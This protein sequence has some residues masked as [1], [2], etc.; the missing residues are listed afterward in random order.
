MG[1]TDVFKLSVHSP[2]DV[3]A[4]VVTVDAGEHVTAAD[5][6]NAARGRPDQQTALTAAELVLIRTSPGRDLEYAWAHRV[7]LQATRLVADAG[8][9]VVNDPIGLE[10][11]SSKLYAACLPADVSPATLVAHSWEAA[12]SW[13]DEL[14]KPVV[15]KPLLGSQG[16]NV[17]FVESVDAPNVKQICE[18]LGQTG[19]LVVQ[20][21]LP[22]AAAG[23]YRVLLLDGT[24]LSVGGREA[25]VHRV[26]RRGEFRSN[27]ALGARAEPA[28]L[29]AAQRRTTARVAQVLADDGIRFSGLDLVGER[30]V[31][32]N[33]YSTGGLVD[34]ELFYDVD[35]ATPV[36]EALLATR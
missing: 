17:F 29:T 23:D 15:I 9:G 32:V 34:A 24:I 21:F 1:M 5:V 25:A 33:V 6:C 11:A 16:R 8:V 20:E 28:E 3:R 31:E 30:I 13:I 4:L 14:G 7:T 26:P 27:V 10:R 19:Y 18:L 12:R 35:Y 2:T 36:I 22:D